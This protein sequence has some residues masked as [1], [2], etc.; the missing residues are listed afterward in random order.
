MRKRIQEFENFGDLRSVQQYVKD[1]QGVQKKLGDLTNQVTLINKE[2]EL[3]KW[4]ISSYPTIKELNTSTE[5]FLRLFQQ[6]LTWQKTQRQWFDGN[7]SDMDPD[8][9]SSDVSANV[10]LEL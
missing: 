1:V 6:T 8:K 2:E 7:F 9:V 3:F 10:W 4:D 5:P